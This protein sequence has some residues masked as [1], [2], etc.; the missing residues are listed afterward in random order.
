MYDFCFEIFSVAKTF[1]SCTVCFIKRRKMKKKCHTPFNTIYYFVVCRWWPKSLPKKPFLLFFDKTFCKLLTNI[2]SHLKISW[3]MSALDLLFTQSPFPCDH[4]YDCTVSLGKPLFRLIIDSVFSFINWPFFSC[5]PFC[6]WDSTELCM[7]LIPMNGT[8]EWVRV[9][10]K[11]HVKYKH[12]NLSLWVT[13]SPFIGVDKKEEGSFYI[14][15][16][17]F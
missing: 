5:N 6:R 12:P 17:W 7:S 2:A 9:S 14:R 3:M 16:K 4:N 1:P 10:C 13:W 11:Y 8:L 15:N